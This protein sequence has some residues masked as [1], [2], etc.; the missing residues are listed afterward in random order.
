MSNYQLLHVTDERLFDIA[1]SLNP[2]DQEKNHIYACQSCL[3]KLNDELRNNVIDRPPRP[4][5]RA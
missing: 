1:A 2:T 4:A 5:K 3:R